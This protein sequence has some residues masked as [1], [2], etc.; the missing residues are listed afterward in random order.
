MLAF[1]TSVQPDYWW[2]GP[3]DL[4]AC[5]HQ[6]LLNCRSKYAALIGMACSCYSEE[7]SSATPL[8]STTVSKAG[9]PFSPLSVFHLDGDFSVL[10]KEIW[11]WSRTDVHAL[12]R[13]ALAWAQKGWR[14]QQSC[15]GSYLLWGENNEKGQGG[16]IGAEDNLKHLLSDSP[17]DT[18]AWGD[19][20]GTKYLRC[21]T[22]QAPALY[23]LISLEWPWCLQETLRL[24][25]QR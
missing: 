22:R 14:S 5:L 25:Q 17:E 16:V 7:G 15:A 6:P 18:A 12:A 9:E 13:Y 4:P 3:R 20:R 21:W 2:Q 23:Y 8:M 19:V 11:K 1:K 24:H 10:Q